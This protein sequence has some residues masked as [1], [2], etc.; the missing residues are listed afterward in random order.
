MLTASPFE[1]RFTHLASLS[2]ETASCA[3]CSPGFH[4]AQLGRGRRL[5]TTVNAS[6][7]W[8]IA[9]RLFVAPNDSADGCVPTAVETKLEDNPRLVISRS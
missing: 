3:S 9:T 8:S 7:P 4:V 5:E 6:N 1:T 2:S